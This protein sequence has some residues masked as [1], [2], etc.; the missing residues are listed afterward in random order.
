[1]LPTGG[2]ARYASPLGVADFRKRTQVIEYS[3]AAAAAHADAIAVLADAE[4]L[5]A[6]GRSAL[7]RKGP[8]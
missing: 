2:A 5:T 4:G 3:A 1:M 6:H 8:P 7:L